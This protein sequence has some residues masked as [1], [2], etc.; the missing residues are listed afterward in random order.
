MSDGLLKFFTALVSFL[1]GLA[2]L[3]GWAYAKEMSSKCVVIDKG[4]HRMFLY[5]DGKVIESYAVSLGID[6]V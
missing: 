4:I 5:R 2:L 6:S 3:L 1:A